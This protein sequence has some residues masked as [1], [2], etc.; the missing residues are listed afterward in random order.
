MLHLRCFT[1]VA[2]LLPGVAR[3]RSAESLESAFPLRFR[4]HS[5]FGAH[6]QGAHLHGRHGQRRQLYA[7]RAQAPKTRHGKLDAWRRLPMFSRNESRQ[8]A[9]CRA[10]VVL[11]AP[12]S[13]NDE[14]APYVPNWT[15]GPGGLSDQDPGGPEE[16]DA[17]Y[18]PNWTWGPG[19]PSGQDASSPQEVNAPD[20]SNW[21]SGQDGMP[22][23]ATRR[24]EEGYAPYERNGTGGAGGVSEFDLNRGRAIDTLRRDYPLLFTTKPDLSI[25]TDD[26]ELWDNRGM[27]ASDLQAYERVFE[28]VRWF[29]INGMDDAELTY[30]LAASPLDLQIRLRWNAKIWL[31]PSP[32]LPMLGVTS[33]NN[34]PIQIDGVSVYDLNSF[35][36]INRHRLENLVM[37]GPWAGPEL[38]LEGLLSLGGQGLAV[39][40]LGFPWPGV[41]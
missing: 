20:V 41:A 2:F 3:R 26:I 30:R 11:A 35:G 36:F 12:S 40:G 14:S 27:L 9:P 19:S 24:P 23:Q 7:P 29:R 18:V 15:G 5:A 17:Q 13:P 1:F 31:R 38:S 28:V 25:F 39:D 10:T 32:L 37:V 34:E 8:A 16:Q 22:D 33:D 6:P 4:S 21:T